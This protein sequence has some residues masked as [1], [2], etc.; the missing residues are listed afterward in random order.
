MMV[1]PLGTPALVG[2]DRGAVSGDG[3]VGGG[4]GGGYGSGYAETKEDDEVVVSALADD[5]SVETDAEADALT[6]A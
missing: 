4:R 2:T 3:A 1:V 5:D 6:F